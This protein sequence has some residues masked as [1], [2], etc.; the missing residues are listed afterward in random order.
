MTD[1]SHR[2]ELPFIAAGQAQKE[3][4]H[5]EAIALIDTL[6]HLSV[7]SMSMSAPPAGP[8]AG[9]AWIVGTSPTAEWAG[10][11]TDIASF[12]D[13]GWRFVTPVA[14]CLA[15]VADLGLFAVR[16]DGGWMSDAWPARALRIGGADMLAPAAP[17]I[18]STAG[19]TTVDTEARATILSILNV[20]RYMG[21][22]AG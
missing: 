1:L 5:N 12:G 18:L 10:H 13:G 3:V 14:G 16:T 22:I 20:L 6:L 7:V 8:L 21:L 19:G 17:A 15:W 2:Y 9:A 11:A 4:T